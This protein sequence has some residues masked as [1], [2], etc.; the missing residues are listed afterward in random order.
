[1][2]ALSFDRLLQLFFDGRMPCTAIVCHL[3][4]VPRVDINSNPCS[5]SV[6]FPTFRFA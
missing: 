5:I 3:L 1:M 2:A 4:L 6:V